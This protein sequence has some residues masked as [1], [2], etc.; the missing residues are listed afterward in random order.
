MV[1]HILLNKHGENADNIF[2]K[3]KYVA[4]HIYKYEIEIVLDS[5]YNLPLFFGMMNYYIIIIYVILI[6]LFR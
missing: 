6:R 3:Y 4:K 5:K 1:R 2:L